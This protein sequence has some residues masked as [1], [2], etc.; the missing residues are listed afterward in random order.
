[1][2][3][4]F[5]LFAMLAL[6]G[7]AYSSVATPVTISSVACTSGVCTV[8]TSSAHSVAANNP[9]FCIVG[10][11][12]TADNICGAAASVPLST[13]YTVNSATMT[14]CSSSCGTSQPAPLFILRTSQGG[15]GLQT[16]L[17]C[18]WTFTPTGAAV[19]GAV[20]ACSAVLPSNLQTEVNAAIAAGTW[21][22]QPI[23]R[24]FPASYSA[25]T[26][27]NQLLDLQLAAQ[28]AL[29]A[30]TAPGSDAGLECDVTGCN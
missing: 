11:T 12:Q 5:I 24:A 21:I 3:Q 18:M 19:S 25:T 9:G 16:I 30:A 23:N 10:S 7:A 22:E 26:I 13:T 1:M 15:F 2:K 4:F 17:G 20:S 27:L 28:V 8:T 29:A 6:C 14:A